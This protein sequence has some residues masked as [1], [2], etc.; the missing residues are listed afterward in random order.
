ML[1]TLGEQTHEILTG[2]FQK[3]N[4]KTQEILTNYILM[5]DNIK[6]TV[7]QFYLCY[8]FIS[9]KIKQESFGELFNKI[10]IVAIK[11]FNMFH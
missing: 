3:I 2:Q 9:N 7:E 6:I 11:D 8:N 10:R 1:T 5:F 4:S